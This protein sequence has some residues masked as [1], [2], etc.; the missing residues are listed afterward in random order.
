MN[1]GVLYA[2]TA[3]VAWGFLPVFWKAMQ[4][5]T[6]L[7]ILAHRIVWSTLFLLLV[8]LLLR[9]WQW[10]RPALSDRRVV[11]TFAIS[12]VALSINWLT[13]I[14]AVNAG[15]VVESSLGYFINPLV[16]VLL[17]VLILQERL[18][19][20]QWAAVGLAAA[21]VLYLTIS[22]GA[23]PWIALTLA[24]SFG[25]YGFVRK[26]A[27]LN[28][29]QGLTLETLFMVVPASL[30]LFY[31]EGTHQAVFGHTTPL[32]SGL[33]M[34][35]GVVTAVPLLLFASGARRIPLSLIGL[36][37]YA[38]PT[39]QFILG[40]FLYH[41]P[42]SVTKLAG[43]VLIWLALAVYSSESLWHHRQEQGLKPVGAS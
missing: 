8:L 38:T 22:L 6:P 11:F 2:L 4:A 26:T 14:W 10:L 41:E 17:G 12:A 25:I 43:F 13:Y 24:F 15:H 35:T 18:R 7:E 39:I 28:S 19:W 5:A 32:L 3:Y 27:S 37:Q 1:R 16:N 36:L 31:L 34:A 9:Q 30:Y 23:L 33:L 40:V 29:L 21:G 42:F 20:G